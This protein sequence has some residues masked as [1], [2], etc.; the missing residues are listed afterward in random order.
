MQG[1]QL[2][3]PVLAFIPVLQRFSNE[4]HLL[5][6]AHHLHFSRCTRIYF[7]VQNYLVSF[8][9]IFISPGFQAN[10]LKVM[11]AESIENMSRSG[12]PL[13]LLG[14][15]YH[16]PHALRGVESSVLLTGKYWQYYTQ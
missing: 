8:A 2:P 7:G 11:W 6:N 14:M 5:C 4:R 9:Y 1:S 16:L 13:I 12:T 15:L 3:L 10:S